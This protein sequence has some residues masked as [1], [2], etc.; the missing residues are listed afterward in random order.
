MCLKEDNAHNI[1]RH[2]L[3]RP[4][5][6]HPE[7][8]DSD[9]SPPRLVFESVVEDGLEDLDVREHGE[10]ERVQVACGLLTVLGTKHPDCGAVLS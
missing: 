4:Q 5:H 1:G 3:A 10:E 9:K 7:S 2:D 8:E 6:I